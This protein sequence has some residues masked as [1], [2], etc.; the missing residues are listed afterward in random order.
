MFRATVA[1]T[2]VANENKKKGVGLSSN[3]KIREGGVWL[4]A[5][6]NTTIFLSFLLILFISC[7][8]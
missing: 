5:P 8:K 2:V 1:V 4:Y 3:D 7:R 6:S